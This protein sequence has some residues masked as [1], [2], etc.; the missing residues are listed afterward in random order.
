MHF[1]LIVL[2]TVSLKCLVEGLH[3]ARAKWYELGLQL[4]LPSGDLDVIQ[5][6]SSSDASSAFREMLKQ[7][8]AG[9]NPSREALEKALQANSV[10]EGRLVKDIQLLET[11]ESVNIPR[12]TF[13]LCIAHD[14]TVI[15]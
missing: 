3:S 13:Q 5:K 6:N 8:L 12:L 4:G 11:C 7:W 1:S 10:D 2:S 9:A 14:K 15:N